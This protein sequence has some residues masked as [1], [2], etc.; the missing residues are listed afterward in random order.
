MKYK[1]GQRVFCKKFKEYGIIIS[2]RENYYTDYPIIV[3]I[4]GDRKTYSLDGR[5]HISEDISLV[6]VF[7]K[8]L[9]KLLSI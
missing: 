4:G 2:I 3:H 7:E 1:V 9:N 6:N 8:K 5:W